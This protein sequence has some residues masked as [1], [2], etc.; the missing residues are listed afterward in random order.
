M[1]CQNRIAELEAINANLFKSLQQSTERTKAL[2]R[3]R[4]LH[5]KRLTGLQAEL[6]QAKI[7]RCRPPPS[8]PCKGSSGGSFLRPD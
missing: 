1:S 4:E 5:I 8:M 3:E 7:C 2:A 6:L